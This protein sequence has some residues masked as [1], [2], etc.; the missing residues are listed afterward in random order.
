MDAQNMNKILQLTQILALYTLILINSTV[1]A[2]EKSDT[3]ENF[4]IGLSGGSPAII[5]LILGY[6]KN[7]FSIRLSGMYYRPNWNGLQFDLGYIFF[8]NYTKWLLIQ[9]E[10]SIVAGTLKID[11]FKVNIGII[12][13]PFDSDMVGVAY[14]AISKINNW[15]YTHNYY[16][17]AYN[18]HLSDFFI[19]LGIANGKGKYKKPFNCIT[20]NQCLTFTDLKMDSL[21]TVEIND[22]IIKSPHLILQVGYMYKF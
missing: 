7:D 2:T 14:S 18:L 10:I 19:Q 16:G 4:S 20:K 21:S 5:N 22:Q 13:S 3:K 9:H 1:S 8:K 15:T 11:P 6:T 17:L 12:Q